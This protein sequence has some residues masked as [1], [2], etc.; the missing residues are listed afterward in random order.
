MKKKTGS[1]CLH[2]LLG[3]SAA[4]AINTQIKMTKLLLKVREYEEVARIYR[5]VQEAYRGRPYS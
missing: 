1:L 3:I 2:I 4:T 5:V